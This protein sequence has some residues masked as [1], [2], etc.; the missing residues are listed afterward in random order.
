MEEQMTTEEEIIELMKQIQRN[1]EDYQEGNKDSVY[2][3]TALMNQI[4]QL[5]R[6]ENGYSSY[7]GKKGG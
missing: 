7:D 5:V 3:M 1:S 2:S 6:K 4:I